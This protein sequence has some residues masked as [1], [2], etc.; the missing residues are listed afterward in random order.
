MRIADLGGER[1]NC[2]SAAFRFGPLSAFVEL[3]RS[4]VMRSVNQP[5][6]LMTSGRNGGRGTS[7]NR[8]TRNGPRPGTGDRAKGSRPEPES[9]QRRGQAEAAFAEPD[10]LDPLDDDEPDDEDDPAEELDED[11]DESDEDPEEPDPDEDSDF[12]VLLVEV[13]RESVR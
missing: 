1:E 2:P 8:P 11:D 12:T 7:R 13:L 4:V 6:E 10:P 3:V 5:T 9:R